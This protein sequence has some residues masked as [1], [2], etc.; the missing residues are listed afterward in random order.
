[1][2]SGKKTRL[3]DVATTLQIMKCRDLG[4][5]GALVERQGHKG[6]FTIGTETMILLCSKWESEADEC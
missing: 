2:S 5:I 4:E 1:M 3:E 6:K